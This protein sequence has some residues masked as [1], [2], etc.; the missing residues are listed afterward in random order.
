MGSGFFEVF[1]FC[2]S[3]FLGFLGFSKGFFLEKSFLCGF[4]KVFGRGFACFFFVHG[5]WLR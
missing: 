5:C 4:L 2:F 1:L 3:A